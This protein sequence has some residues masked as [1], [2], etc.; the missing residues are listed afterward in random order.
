MSHGLTKLFCH[1]IQEQRI[2]EW[3]IKEIQRRS[4]SLTDIVI[5]EWHTKV[6]GANVFIEATVTHKID[7]DKTAGPVKQMMTLS[8]SPEDA[9]S[10]FI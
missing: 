8:V 4:E 10:L 3:I 7:W 1:E 2:R 9:N 5:K 6:V